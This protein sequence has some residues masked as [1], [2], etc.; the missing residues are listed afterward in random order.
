MIFG[1]SYEHASL[2]NSA[3]QVIH[4]LGVSDKGGE[5]VETPGNCDNK[6]PQLHISESHPEASE[7]ELWLVNSGNTECKNANWNHSV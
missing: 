5:K 6:D 2:G 1:I 7:M 4:C 3:V